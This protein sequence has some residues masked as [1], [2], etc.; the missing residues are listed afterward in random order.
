[1]MGLILILVSPLLIGFLFGIGFQ[2]AK[3]IIK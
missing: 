1:M 3:K 2:L